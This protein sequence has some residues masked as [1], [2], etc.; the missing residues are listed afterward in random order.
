[1]IPLLQGFIFRGRKGKGT[2]LIQKSPLP[3]GLVRFSMNVR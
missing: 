3:L 1:V 2:G